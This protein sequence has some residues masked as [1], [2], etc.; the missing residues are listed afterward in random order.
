MSEVVS[1]VVESSGKNFLREIEVHPFVGLVKVNPRRALL[2]ISIAAKAGDYSE[3]V[4]SDLIE[5][6]PSVVSPRLKRVFLAR[7]ARLPFGLIQKVGC[8][9]GLWFQ[10][11]IVEILNFSVE[12]TWVAFDRI[13]DGIFNGGE[14]AARSALLRSG[15]NSTRTFDHAINSSTGLCATALVNAIL[16]YSSDAEVSPIEAIKSRIERLLQAPGEG[17]NYAALIV[18]ARLNVMMEV[19]PVWTKKWIIPMLIFTHPAAEAVWHGFLHQDQ[20]PSEALMVEIKP[21]LVDLFPWIERFS[22]YQL[23]MRAAHLLTVAR[24]HRSGYVSQSEMRSALRSMVDETRV[25]V[26]FWLCQ[27]KFENESD[28]GERVTSFVAENWPRELRYRTVAATK[29]WARLLDESGEALPKLYEAVKKHLVPVDV[30]GD[31]LF[32][33]FTRDDGEEKALAARFPEVALDLFDTVTPS[34][35]TFPSYEL[36][37]VLMLIAEVKP[38]LT[39]DPRYLRLINLVEMG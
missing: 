34:E 7:L 6:F 20:Y 2:A 38:D 30:M 33:R 8:L 27:V 28:W 16:A 4:W 37:Q 10:K 5:N 14:S 19:D 36:S 3:G 1:K 21:L 9:L 11:N 13:V 24:M 26:V 25:Q 35:L 32:Y 15:Q 29:A 18:A 31:S 39:T 23:S 12:L 17:G 22:N